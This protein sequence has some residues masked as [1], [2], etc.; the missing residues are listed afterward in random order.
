MNL[1]LRLAL[2][3]SVL[4]AIILAISCTTIY[5]LYKSYRTENYKQR[6]INE[7]DD[8][9]DAFSLTNISDSNNLNSFKDLNNNTL[10]YSNTTLVNSRYKIIYKQLSDSEFTYLKDTSLYQKIKSEKVYSFDLKN[11][12][13]AIGVYFDTSNTYI[14]ISAIDINGF[15]KLQNLKYILLGVFSGALIITGLI[16]FFFVQQ[17]LSPLVKLSSQMQATSAT[18]LSIQIDEN[19]GYDE[20]NIIARNFNAMLKRLNDAFERQRTFVQNASH[21]LRTPL[22]TMLSQTEAAL[23]RNLDVD[24]YKKVMKSLKEDQTDLIEL[25]NSLLLISQYEKMANADDWPL[26]RV[27]EM[28]YDTVAS[29]KRMFPR[30]EIMIDFKTLPED[31]NELMVKGNDSLLKSVF[32]NLIKNAYKYSDNKKVN[33]VIET[34]SPYINI[35]FINT[36]KQLQ[37]GEVDKMKMPFFRG[38]NSVAKKGYGLGLAIVATILELHKGNITYNALGNNTNQFTISLLGFL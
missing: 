31:E 35:Q 29:C 9:N 32:S 30:I 16:A 20:I 13:E 27:D 14:I 23:N 19:N 15:K 5:L 25:T 24:G 6:L 2:L 21:E 22:A 3:F 10:S 37:Q 26:I 34:G 11:N 12:R 18:N 4:V 17:A 28:I 33:I 1:K 7:A 38:D 8:F 36:G